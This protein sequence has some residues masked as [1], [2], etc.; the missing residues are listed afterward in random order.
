M[1]K[2]LTAAEIIALKELF[3]LFD[4]DNSGTITIDEL[5]VG[6]EKNG[7]RTAFHEL[8]HLMKS[9]DMVGPDTRGS[10]SAQLQHLRVY[11]R[12]ELSGYGYT[13]A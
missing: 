8:E 2:T 6:L 11:K 12:D 7:A 5:K 4:T 10:F 3:R 13:T 1:A 9:I